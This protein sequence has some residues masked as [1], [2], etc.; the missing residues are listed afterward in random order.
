MHAPARTCFGQCGTGADEGFLAVV[1]DNKH[2]F[3]R[4]SAEEME[5]AEIMQF[6]A[7]LLRTLT[8]ESRRH[9]NNNLLGRVQ[10]IYQMKFSLDK[11]TQKNWY[12]SVKRWATYTRPKIYESRMA[13]S[14]TTTIDVLEATRHR[15]KEPAE[16]L[17]FI[18][19]RGKCVVYDIVG[20]IT[21]S[22]ITTMLASELQH[23]EIESPLQP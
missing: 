21:L 22:D 2:R 15:P 18:S 1:P 14:G 19:G 17:I 16:F 4:Y 11:T 5:G 23:A 10:V 8:P 12:D 6:P 3:E 9:D 20:Y 13:I 7:E